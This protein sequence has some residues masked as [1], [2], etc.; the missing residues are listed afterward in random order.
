VFI[1]AEDVPFFVAQA[2]F[3]PLKLDHPSKATQ[4]TAKFGFCLNFRF[5]KLQKWFILKT[6]KDGED[7]FQALSFMSNQG[8]E[9]NKCCGWY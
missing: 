7:A 2:S 4:K 9:E 6:S 5:F 3:F 1:G 8:E